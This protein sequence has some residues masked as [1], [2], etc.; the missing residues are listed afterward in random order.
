MGLPMTVYDICSSSE[1]GTGE[2]DAVFRA[3][4]DFGGSEAKVQVLS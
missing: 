3:S 4:A 2:A 1:W